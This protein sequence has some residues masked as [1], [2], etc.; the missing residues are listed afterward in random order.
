MSKLIKI[1]ICYPGYFIGIVKLSKLIKF[2]V[3]TMYFWRTIE[4]PS[5][6]PIFKFG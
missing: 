5:K 4:K 2:N 3:S 1:Q 6:S